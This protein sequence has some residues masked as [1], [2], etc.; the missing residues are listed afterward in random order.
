MKYKKERWDKK[1]HVNNIEDV[2]DG[3]LY[4]ERFTPDGFYIDSRQ[5]DD[6][7]H[8][9]LQKNTD[10]VT[11]FNSSKYQVWPVYFIINELPPNLR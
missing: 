4:K 5:N 9:S 2:M 7:C 11:V 3:Q 10:G 8:L 1:K 6:E